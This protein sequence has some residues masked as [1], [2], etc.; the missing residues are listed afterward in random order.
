MIRK[1]LKSIKNNRNLII[2]VTILLA[3]FGVL[4][5]Y[6]NKQSKLLERLI[7]VS[8]GTD[9]SIQ[10]VDSSIN[11]LMEHMDEGDSSPVD[12]VSDY[13]VEPGEP[14]FNTLTADIAVTIV[15]KEFTSGTTA[16]M[17]IDDNKVE[18]EAKDNKYTG[19]INV[20]ILKS[21]TKASVSFKKKNVINNATL[22]IKVSFA[23]YF[24]KQA[25][26]A[27]DGDKKYEQGEYSYDGNIVWSRTAN[28]FDT[29]L[30]SKLVRSV[31]G[32]VQWS[33]EIPIVNEDGEQ[34]F[35]VQQSFPLEIES[36]FEYYIE[37]KSKS[38]FTYRY[39]IDGGS[40]KEDEVYVPDERQVQCQVYDLEGNSLVEQ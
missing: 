36:T 24:T 19:I 14:D 34:K 23:D 39:F 37:Q 13:S 4:V 22:A 10:N 9:K 17:Y 38:G 5:F 15:P 25:T 40:V 6:Q 32:V 27:F 31:N 2:V 3:Q 20:S 7:K 33:K 8:E 18:L 35:V 26:V 30:S 28:A 11:Y 29:I 16:I 1:C 12:I 21:Y